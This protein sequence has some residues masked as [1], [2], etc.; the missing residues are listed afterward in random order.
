ML[1]PRTTAA[2][3]GRLLLPFQLLLLGPPLVAIW[4]AGF[5]ALVR[6]PAWRPLR[7]VALAY[8][9][10]LLI[11]FAGGGQIYYPLGLMVFLFA[12]G[13]VPTTDW[14]ARRPRVRRPLV[15]GAV[16]INAVVTAVLALPLVPVDRLGRTP[17]PEINQVARDQVGWPVYTR[18]VAD[19]FRVCRRRTRPRRS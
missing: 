17:I 11:T 13:S 15:A 16:A 1:W 2:R 14:I 7:A 9:V 6:R 18:Q 8:P 10:V 3:T 12:A 4:V 5:V 19:V